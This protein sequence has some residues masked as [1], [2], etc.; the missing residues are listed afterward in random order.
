MYIHA[1]MCSVP[2][3]IYFDKSANKLGNFI[4]FFIN[5]Y[6]QQFLFILYQYCLLKLEILSSFFG[7]DIYRF[8]LHHYKIWVFSYYMK[9]NIWL[10]MHYFWRNIYRYVF[11]TYKYWAQYKLDGVNVR[12][13]KL[14]WQITTIFRHWFPAIIK[15]K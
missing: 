3:K 13:S 8:L 6:I 15:Y 5:I 14:Y 7:R 9:I 2:W 4:S 11:G 12:H 10:F 1:S